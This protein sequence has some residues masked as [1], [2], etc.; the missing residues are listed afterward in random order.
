VSKTIVFMIVCALGGVLLMALDGP[1][2]MNAAEPSAFVLSGALLLGL[3]WCAR[4][5]F[6][7][8]RPRPGVGPAGVVPSASRTVAER[9]VA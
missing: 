6:P 8:M 4:R 7:A 3:A 9:E 2:T 5:L 1:G